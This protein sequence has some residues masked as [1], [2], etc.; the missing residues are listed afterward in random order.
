LVWHER[1]RVN[2]HDQD[3][4]LIDTDCVELHGAFL[5]LQLRGMTRRRYRRTVPAPTVDLQHPGAF[6]VFGLGEARA[7]VSAAGPRSW[8]AQE[9]WKLDA[10]AEMSE[11]PG[12][13][14]PHILHVPG[15][16][17]KQ[18]AATDTESK[19]AAT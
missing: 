12:K 2:T 3:G 5:S 14:G 15:W 8:M 9:R 1:S 13:S 4:A 19:K 18:A 6:V 17:R 10:E 11:N 7:D 16:L